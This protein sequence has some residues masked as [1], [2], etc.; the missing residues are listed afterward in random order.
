MNTFDQAARYTAKLNPP[1]FYSWLLRDPEG[2]LGFRDWLDTRTVPFPGERD[3]TCDTVAGF[4]N[5]SEP[6]EPF[7][8]VTEFQT[9]PARDALERLAEYVI[10]LRRELR[11]GAEREGKYHVGG[12][13]VNLT[14]PSGPDVLHMN[15]P[16]AVPGELRFQPVVRALREEDAAGTLSD[17]AAGRV[18]RCILPW[19]PLMHGGAEPGIIDQWKQVAATEPDSHL[20]STYAGLALIFAE[21]T[22]CV[23]QWQQALEGWNV[24]ESQVVLGWKLEARRADLLHVL[25]VRFRTEVPADLAAVVEGISDPDELTRWF[26]AALTSDSLEEFRAAVQA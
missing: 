13:L 21:L 17:I 5:P 25:R 4:D 2:H 1:G 24:R 10:R 15:V 16:G 9:E 6:E 18:A 8:L 3:R 19:I 22:H 11:H 20:R 26:N 14:G 12:A 7:A 23:T